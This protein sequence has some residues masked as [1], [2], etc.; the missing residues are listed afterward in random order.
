MVTA[1]PAFS[2]LKLKVYTS[3][4]PADPG[5]DDSSDK[6]PLIDAALLVKEELI[7]TTSVF[8]LL[9]VKITLLP[10]TAELNPV[11]APE[12]LA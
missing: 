7:V 11:R 8:G 1:S 9:D 10:L 6:A 4:T 3:V 12:K 5:V 2:A